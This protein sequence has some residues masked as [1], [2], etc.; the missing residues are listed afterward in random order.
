MSILF[1]SSYTSDIFQKVSFALTH[2]IEDSY[3]IPGIQP[4]CSCSWLKTVRFLFLGPRATFSLLHDGAARSSRGCVL[5][6]LP[7]TTQRQQGEKVGDTHIQPQA[8]TNSLFPRLLISS[9]SGLAPSPSCL[10]PQE[11]SA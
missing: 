3:F 9:K 7:R 10:S 4:N 11:H 6:T 2:G 5:S 8:P 1:S